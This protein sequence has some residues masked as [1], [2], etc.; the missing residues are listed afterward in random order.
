MPDV[1]DFPGGHVGEDE[2]AREA[3]ARELVEE[4]GVSLPVPSSE[5]DELLEF[6][7]GAV[8]VA[9][10]F[11]RYGGPVDNRAADEHDDIRWMTVDEAAE[12]KLADRIYPQLIGRALRR[13]ARR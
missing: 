6:D 5:P 12:V 11:L 1:W 13:L 9:V 4:L 7:G 8:R 3:L 10:W 2:T